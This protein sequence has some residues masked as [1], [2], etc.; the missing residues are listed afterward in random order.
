MFSLLRIRWI[1][2]GPLLAL[3]SKQRRWTRRYIFLHAD[4]YTPE[5]VDEP[6][7][8]RPQF[9]LQGILV[10]TTLACV[11]LAGYQR[12]SLIRRMLVFLIVVMLIL[13]AALYSYSIAYSLLCRRLKPT[14]TR[15]RSRLKQSYSLYV[16]LLQS[17]D[18]LC[19]CLKKNF[20]EKFASGKAIC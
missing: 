20:V 2:T 4:Q 3:R 7:A 1:G 12:M 17:R 9:T 18:L 11:L 14:K 10:F 13:L 6:I 8:R 16:E 15:A 19:F 5:F